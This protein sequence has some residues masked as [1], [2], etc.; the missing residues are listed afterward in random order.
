MNNIKH[1]I[2]YME[3]AKWK[4]KPLVIMA[5]YMKTEVINQIA[6][7]YK[8]KI[9]DVYYIEIPNRNESEENIL[10]EDLSTIFNST[11]LSKI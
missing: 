5:N 11:F 10:L 2:E 4:G 7:Y 9:F 1:L 3:L 6:N 8:N